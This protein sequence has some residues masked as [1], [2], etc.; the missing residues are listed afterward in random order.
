MGF[1]KDQP[2]EIKGQ[3]SQDCEPLPGGVGG[4]DPHPYNGL[5]LLKGPWVNQLRVGG[6][7]AGEQER[8]RGE[9]VVGHEEVAGLLCDKGHRNEQP[10]QLVNTWG[11]GASWA[12]N[13]DRGD[14]VH[15]SWSTHKSG[16]SI[17]ASTL[18]TSLELW[19]ATGTIPSCGRRQV[20]PPV[21]K[22][23]KGQMSGSGG[24][25]GPWRELTREFDGAR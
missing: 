12:R 19:V 24:K 3:K 16:K 5:N 21:Q 13:H 17:V 25:F 14:V 7:V 15:G 18:R 23:H 9:E 22:Q 1:C 2:S 4:A 8:N 20:R 6:G 10:F 11:R